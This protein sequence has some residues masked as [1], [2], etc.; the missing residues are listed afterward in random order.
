MFTTDKSKQDGLVD[1]GWI[2]EN[3]QFCAES[4]YSRLEKRINY[5]D[6]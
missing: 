2:N 4:A 1:A 6:D 5:C 3:I